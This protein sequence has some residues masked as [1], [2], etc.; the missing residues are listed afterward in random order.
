[1]NIIIRL[2]KLITHEHKYVKVPTNIWIF[3][4]KFKIALE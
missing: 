1:M 3:T 4:G 2:T